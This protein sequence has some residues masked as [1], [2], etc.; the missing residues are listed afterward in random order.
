MKKD[1]KHEAIDLKIKNLTKQ[2]GLGWRQIASEEM[3]VKPNTIY[4]YITGKKDLYYNKRIKL[5]T[6]LIRLD[7]AKHKQANKLTDDHLIDLK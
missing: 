5:L 2:L 6:I 7:Q 1:K 3:G 4:S